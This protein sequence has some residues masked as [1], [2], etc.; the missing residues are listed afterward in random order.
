[1]DCPLEKLMFPDLV[2]KISLS[3]A[4]CWGA[5][6]EKLMFPDLVSK[7]SHPTRQT[8]NNVGKADVPGLGFKAECLDVG[9]VMQVG[10]ADVPGLGKM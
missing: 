2:S 7:C 9:D 1:M 4:S 8:A 6:W 10:K 5:S 3:V